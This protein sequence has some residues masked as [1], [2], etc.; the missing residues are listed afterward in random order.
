[1]VRET[2]DTPLV[3]IPITAPTDTTPFSVLGLVEQLLTEPD[4]PLLEY[5]TIVGIALIVTTN[6]VVKAC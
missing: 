6:L 3:P 4:V 5:K 2:E 1:V